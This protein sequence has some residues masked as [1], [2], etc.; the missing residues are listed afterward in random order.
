MSSEQPEIMMREDL[1]DVKA[2]LIK[3]AEIILEAMLEERKRDLMNPR[4][5]R[6]EFFE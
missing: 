2:D 6:K 1:S 5:Q 4:W 3:N